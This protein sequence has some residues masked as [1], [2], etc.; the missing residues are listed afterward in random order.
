MLALDLFFERDLRAGKKAHGHVWFSD[1]GKTI[2]D[3]VA[4]F[5]RHHQPGF[6]RVQ[7]IIDQPPTG[8]LPLIV[9]T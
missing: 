3:R 1:R 4:E 8:D 7:L 5:R 9:N 2:S 6:R